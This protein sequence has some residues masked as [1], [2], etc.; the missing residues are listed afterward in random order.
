MTVISKDCKI[1]LCESYFFT[2]MLSSVH[3]YLL[4]V[5]HVHIVKESINA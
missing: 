2:Q 3:Y 4:K 5:S 1:E